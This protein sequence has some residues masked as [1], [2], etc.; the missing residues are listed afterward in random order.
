MKKADAV[1]SQLKVAELALAE[2][3]RTAYWNYY[4]ARQ[5]VLVIAE[6]RASLVALREA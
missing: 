2:R 1:R 5:T 3:V 6:S 4:A